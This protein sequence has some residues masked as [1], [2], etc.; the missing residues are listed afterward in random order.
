VI[1]KSTAGDSEV[2]KRLTPKEAVC[3]LFTDTERLLGY[4]KIFAVP[5]CRLKAAIR[6]E[7]VWQVPRGLKF[8]VAM[9]DKR[10]ALKVA[11][12]EA[13]LVSFLE[14]H[15]SS[16]KATLFEVSAGARFVWVRFE[17]NHQ[18]QIVNIKESRVFKIDK[19]M[20]SQLKRT[21]NLFFGDGVKSFRLQFA[22]NTDHQFSLMCGVTEGY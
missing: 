2:S 10:G 15:H 13:K 1:K 4:Y 8:P 18:P 6:K 16:P 21:N 3:A 7:G 5:Q 9:Y 14:K 19:A 20:L 17:V 11:L 22:V 12:N